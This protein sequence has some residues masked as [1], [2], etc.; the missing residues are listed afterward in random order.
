M[1][2]T[3]ETSGSS[4]ASSRSAAEAAA[5]PQVHRC[6]MAMSPRQAG[7]VAGTGHDVIYEAIRDK[8]LAARKLGR[9]TIIMSD[10]LEQWL[11]SLPPLVLRSKPPK[12]TSAAAVAST[13]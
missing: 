4:R 6:S 8:K 9:R 13:S 5:V 11:K 3:F 1:A 10:D 12:R 7:V 2:Q